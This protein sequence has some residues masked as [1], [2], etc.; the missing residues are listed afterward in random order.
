MIPNEWR[1]IVGSLQ[2]RLERFDDARRLAVLAVACEH[3]LPF[4][5][6]AARAGMDVDPE[7]LK[8][9][10]DIVWS[11]SEGRAP[12]VTF[13]LTRADAQI[14][15]DSAGV[16]LSGHGAEQVAGVVRCLS[17]ADASHDE[18]PSIERALDALVGVAGYLGDFG[19]LPEQELAELERVATTLRDRPPGTS[20]DELR[21]E[22]RG[23]GA[24]LLARARAFELWD[25]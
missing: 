22:A 2:D 10:I 21:Q 7:V 1:E 20:V 14:P 8:E 12:G 15:T 9:A 3:L 23:W 25:R 19:D 17:V 6:E 13:D 24:T 4:V 18:E 5:E 11:W 16:G